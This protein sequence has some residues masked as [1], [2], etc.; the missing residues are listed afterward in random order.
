MPGTLK[1][2]MINKNITLKKG[3]SLENQKILGTDKKIK[4]AKNIAFNE[5]LYI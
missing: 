4:N 5:N 3:A 2:D 1:I